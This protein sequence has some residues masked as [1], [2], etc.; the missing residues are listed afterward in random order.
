M[1]RRS[2]LE[3]LEDVCKVDVDEVD[4]DIIRSLPFTPHNQ[5]S[6]QAIITAELLK[7]GNEDFLKRLVAKYGES[8][9][10]MV[11]D[12]AAVH[13]CARNVAHISERVLVQVSP[14]HVNNREAIIQQCHFFAKAFEDLGVPISRF[15]IKLPFS[16]SAAS[17]ARD[18]QAEGIQTLATAVFSLEQAIAANQAGCLLISPYYNEIAAHFDASLR[19]LVKDPALEHPMSACIIHILEMYAELYR[20]T[21][22]EPPIMVVASHLNIA[23]ILAMAELGC[24]H[25]T[26]NGHNL[27][28]L[29]ESPD[30]LPQ[31]SIRKPK[32]PYAGF[33]TVERLKALSTKDSLTGPSWTRLSNTTDYIVNGGA[34]LDAFIRSDAFVG[35][36]FHDAVKFFL[37]EEKKAKAA[38]EAIYALII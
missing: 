14:R 23:E 11:Y 19:H 4:T 24:A 1:A 9:W 20:E 33:Q 36:R 31:A 18:L 38:I 37:E 10:E 25:V 28:V 29:I 30:T 35:K 13:L 12:M 22:K 8:G 27:R 15:A 21:G 17:A 7:S 2:L 34:K 5:T 16:G 3:G 26:I 6:N 32:H